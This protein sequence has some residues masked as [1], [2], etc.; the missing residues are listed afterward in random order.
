MMTFYLFLRG[1]FLLLLLLL[2]LLRRFAFQ[3]TQK[4]KASSLKLCR[5]TRRRDFRR[6]PSPSWMRVLVL[7]QE[8]TVLVMFDGGPQLIGLSV[9]AYVLNSMKKR[10]DSFPGLCVR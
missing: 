10:M 3:S 8:K 2:L 5:L 7:R 1:V 9:R 4:I 6:N